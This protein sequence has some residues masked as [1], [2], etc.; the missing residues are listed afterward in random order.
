MFACNVYTY[1]CVCVCGQNP[2]LGRE[3]SYDRAGGDTD[4]L[5]TEQTDEETHRAAPGKLRLLRYIRALHSSS[6]FKRLLYSTI[7]LFVSLMK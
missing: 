3:V 6:G 5:S 7:Y 4:R 2:R 1:V